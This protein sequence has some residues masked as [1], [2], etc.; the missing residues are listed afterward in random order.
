MTK[1]QFS[2][3]WSLLKLART[4]EP[5]DIGGEVVERVLREGSP[6]AVA[7]ILRVIGA[8]G[9]ED[10]LKAKERM[11]SVI[12]PAEIIESTLLVAGIETKRLDGGDRPAMMINLDAHGLFGYPFS[13]MEPAVAYVT[14][15]V[16]AV[17]R[18]AAVSES[19]NRL[20]IQF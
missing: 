1:G 9:F 4:W 16:Q 5:L 18:G 14:G 8:I 2:R 11:P 19:E 15:F 7:D 13:M 6:E 20:L 3:D 12:E 10:G 17:S